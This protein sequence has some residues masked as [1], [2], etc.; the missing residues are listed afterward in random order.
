MVVLWMYCA[1]CW[2]DVRFCGVTVTGGISRV[3]KLLLRLGLGLGC[4]YWKVSTGKLPVT[5]PAGTCTHMCS[6]LYTACLNAFA[7]S[8]Y[9]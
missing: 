9:M 3:S 2:I 8:V 1:L 5:Q 6:V 4:W 7:S